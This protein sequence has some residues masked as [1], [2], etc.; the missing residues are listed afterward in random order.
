M[1]FIKTKCKFL[2]ESLNFLLPTENSFVNLTTCEELS[3]SWN[4]TININ[5]RKNDLPNDIDKL[6]TK[7]AAGNNGSLRFQPKKDLHCSLLNI[8]E[9]PSIEK[10]A[11][12]RDRITE[13]YNSNK[14]VLRRI[15]KD[16]VGKELEFYAE[17]I[18]VSNESLALQIFIDQTIVRKLKDLQDDFNDC[19]NKDIK[20]ANWINKLKLYPKDDDTGDMWGSM[21]LVRF[22]QEK[23]DENLSKNLSNFIKK[24][25][26]N[27]IEER[28]EVFSIKFTAKPYLVISDHLFSEKSTVLNLND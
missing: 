14:K 4:L 24:Y 12:H 9:A 27:S 20:D 2:S 6:K 25:N 11:N 15:L 18:Y 28:N 1:N 23:L 7:I 19:L 26:Q 17:F 5:F 21:N 10:S 13:F 3:K 8:A 22:E 16:F